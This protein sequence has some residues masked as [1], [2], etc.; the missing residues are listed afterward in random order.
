MHKYRKLFSYGIVMSNTSFDTQDSG[1]DYIP[2][3]F[4]YP[5]YDENAIINLME[6]QGKIVEKKG[7]D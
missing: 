5:E 1:F 7:L 6:L 2:K 4:Q 3:E